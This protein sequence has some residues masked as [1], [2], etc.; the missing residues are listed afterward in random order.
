[1]FEKLGLADDRSDDLARRLLHWRWP[2]GGWNCHRT[3]GADTSSFWE[4]RHPMLG[5]A[6][7]AK[8]TKNLAA[9]E[10]GLRAAEVFLSRHLS[11]G[12]HNG[13]V[14]HKES[15]CS[16]A[17]CTITMTSSGGSEQWPRWG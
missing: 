8:R 6:L 3:P 14:M 10:A 2:D 9:K 1:M 11:L 7:Y 17:P 4:T 12:R 15:P 13:Q 5:L 16:T